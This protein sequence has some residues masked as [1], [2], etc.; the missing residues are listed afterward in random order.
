MTDLSKLGNLN[1]FLPRDF[2]PRIR[3]N[4]IENIAKSIPDGSKIIDISAGSKPYKHLFA[5]CEYFSHEFEGNKDILDS[6]RGEKDKSLFQTHDYYGDICD[7]LPIDDESFDYV[8]CTEVIEHVAEP[9]QAIKE[10]TRICKKGGQ[11]IITAPF[12]SGLHQ[13]PHHY[14]AGFSPHFYNYVAKKYDLTVKEIQSQG[15]FF[16]LM[17]WFTNLAMQFRLPYC[18]DF[19]V[20]T[21][22]H[23]MQSFYLTM[24]ETFGDTSGNIVETSKHFTIGY[25]V[26]FEKK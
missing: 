18:D 24:S 7:R 4:W 25:M 20:N 6:F 2:N 21:V 12:T 11:I 13:E 1:H 16:K 15:D 19:I 8:F 3:D 14:Y 23:Y 10:M 26:I 5:H 22:S 9:I 17:S